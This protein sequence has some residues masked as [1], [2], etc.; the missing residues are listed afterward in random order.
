MKQLL[1]VFITLSIFI[2]SPSWAVSEEQYNKYFDAKISGDFVKIMEVVTDIFMTENPNSLTIDDYEILS[3]GLGF[4]HQFNYQLDEVQQK[5]F[6]KFFEIPDDIDGLRT[7]DIL[8]FAWLSQWDNNEDLSVKRLMLNWQPFFSNDVEGGMS[9]DVYSLVNWKIAEKSMHEEDF[10]T[11]ELRMLQEYVLGQENIHDP[12]ESVL[13]LSRI[14]KLYHTMGKG[15]LAVSVAAHAHELLSF[16]RK[17]PHLYLAEIASNLAFVNALHGNFEQAEFYITLF[18]KQG[19]RDDISIDRK[20]QLVVA[21]VDAYIAIRTLDFKRIIKA[22]E[23]HEKSGWEFHTIN[24]DYFYGYATSYIETM[25]SED[26]SKRVRV[27]SS[28]IQDESIGNVMR[29]ME[30][31]MR[32]L[33]K[34]FRGLETS[35]N[36]LIK[37]V[38]ASTKASY[39]GLSRSLEP[40][41]HS[42]WAEKIVL[43]ALSRVQI[44][45][46]TLNG[47]LTNLAINF[48]LKT[49]SSPAEREFEAKILAQRSQSPKAEGNIRAY[50]NLLRERDI[51]LQRLFEQYAQKIVKR[52]KEGFPSDKEFPL[53]EKAR[54]YNILESRKNIESY[55]TELPSRTVAEIQKNLISSQVSIFNIDRGD[56]Q[57]GCIVS[58]KSHY[59]EIVAKDDR[60]YAAKQSVLDAI[61]KRSLL[62]VSEDIKIITDT[63]FS[64]KIRLLAKKSREVFYVPTSEDWRLPINLLWQAAEIPAALIVT[65]TLSMLTHR[66]AGEKASA[67]RYSYTGIGNPDYNIQSVAS[68]S[69]LEKI[70]GFSLRSAGYVEQLSSLSQ[71]PST[72]EEVELSRMNFDDNSRVFLGSEASEDKLMDVDWYDSEIIHFATHALISGEMKG[73]EEPAIALSRPLNGDKF[74]GLLTTTDIR[75]FNFPNSTVLLSGCRTATDYGAQS[76]N[77][78]TGLSLAFLAQGANNLLVTQWQVPDEPSSR[79]VSHITQN[80]SEEVSADSVVRATQEIADEYIDPFDWAAYIFIST[81]GRYNSRGVTNSISGSGDS[82][83]NVLGTP[84]DVSSIR[85]SGANFIGVSTKQEGLPQ[86]SFKI[87]KIKDEKYRLVSSFHGYGGWFIDSAEG[88]YAFVISDTEALIVKFNESMTQWENKVQLFHTKDKAVI[89]YARPKSSG[90]GFVF[91][92]KGGY[93]G[94]SNLFVKMLKVGFDLQ[95]I[96]EQ[97]I[98]VDVFGVE[99]PNHYRGDVGWHL[100]VK[101]QDISLAVSRNFLEP[102]FEPTIGG[103][104][105]PLRRHT[106]FY[107]YRNDKFESGFLKRHTNVL[108]VMDRSSHTFITAAGKNDALALISSNGELISVNEEISNIEWVVPFKVGGET[109]LSVSSAKMYSENSYFDIFKSSSDMVSIVQ[110]DNMAP[111]SLNPEHVIEKY[112]LRELEESKAITSEEKLANALS[113]LLTKKWIYQNSIINPIAK[114]L[115]PIVTFPST[116][117]VRFPVSFF[118]ENDSLKKIDLVNYH[119]LE[120][121]DISHTVLQH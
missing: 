29:V 68:L 37:M 32:T 48:F 19:S 45:R 4:Y 43:T 75:G 12:W 116:P 69:S 91:A 62:D 114:G 59:C 65:P 105:Y 95:E 93:P 103:Y 76:A 92:Y 83:I 98:T 42:F 8:Y 58:R 40:Y 111:V 31:D 90:D 63:K 9:P 52:I 88:V 106:Y 85:V 15:D 70:N 89:N 23:R 49:E 102:F 109:Y 41:S 79:L 67:A 117:T 20:A 80:I 110:D 53:F 55:I 30:I 108:G 61:E 2:S 115:E 50:F 87:F 119:R 112:R 38:H 77:G 34:D 64:P 120:W 35:L 46:G 72:K 33:C 107:N 27:D 113:F 121:K 78:I 17:T 18:D 26:C 74:D 11:S 94:D 22:R 10:V 39:L 84:T 44:H 13:H 118:S 86:K 56:Y 7:L 3:T 101:G 82:S 14:S 71:L 21:T 97:D 104:Q 57:L 51:Y 60:Y 5:A 73:I 36:D 100:S 25:S 47:K 24:E 1:H 54:E 16:L 96:T 81:P 6:I 28:Q 99:T 66:D